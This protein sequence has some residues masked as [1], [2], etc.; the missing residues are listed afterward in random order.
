MERTLFFELLKL[1]EASTSKPNALDP[2][3]QNMAHLHISGTDVRR[4][5]GKIEAAT[6]GQS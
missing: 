6:S 1:Y 3:N 2:P 4:L 5:D